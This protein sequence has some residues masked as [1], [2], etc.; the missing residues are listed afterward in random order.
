MGGDGRAAPSPDHSA[1][2]AP[3]GGSAHEAVVQTERREA[4]GGPPS[5]LAGHCGKWL[6]GTARAGFVYRDTGLWFR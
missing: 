5:D 1:P 3:T 4:Q 2:G 6:T